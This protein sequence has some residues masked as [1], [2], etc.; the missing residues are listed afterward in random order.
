MTAEAA[1]IRCHH[2][3][4]VENDPPELALLQVADELN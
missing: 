2:R 3:K 1:I 4:L